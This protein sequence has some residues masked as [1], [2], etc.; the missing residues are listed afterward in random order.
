MVPC[1]DVGIVGVVSAL[2]NP[3]AWADPAPG[4]FGTGAAYYSDYRY[5]RIPQENL[6]VGR[7]FR[8]GERASFNIRA[9]FSNI[10]NRSRLLILNSSQGNNLTSINA[11]ATRTGTDAT[12]KSVTIISD[13][14]FS[15]GL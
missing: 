3:N 6:A 5:P 13:G 15:D 4:Q 11:K 2:M 14:A 12:G 8:I 1:L 10:F 9:E 7:T